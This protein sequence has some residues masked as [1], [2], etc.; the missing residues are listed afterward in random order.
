[1]THKLPAAWTG[2]RP[3]RSAHEFTRN[4]MHATASLG[5]LTDYSEALGR[6]KGPAR[7][8]PALDLCETFLD[9]EQREWLRLMLEMDWY[10]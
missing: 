6:E 7:L 3:W 2:I 4:A 9:G 1:V 5:V 8:L 10:G